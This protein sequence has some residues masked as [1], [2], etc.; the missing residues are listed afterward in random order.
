VPA[1][2]QKLSP[3]EFEILKILWRIESGTVAQV[4]EQQQ[5]PGGFAPAY[6]TTMTMLGRLVEKQAVRVDKDRQPF[7]YKPALRRATLLKRHLREFVRTVYEGE[8]ELLISQILSE[9]YLDEKEVASVVREHARA[10][11]AEHRS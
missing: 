2:P 3:G 7:R 1:N 9:G 10:R 8:A 11:E 5:G 4:R 6:T